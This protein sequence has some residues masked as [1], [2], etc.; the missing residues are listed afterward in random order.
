MNWPVLHMEIAN[1]VKR[2]LMEHQA[3]EKWVETVTKF[4]YHQNRALLIFM[5]RHSKYGSKN[6]AAEGHAGTMVRLND[7]IQRIRHGTSNFS[8]ESIEDAH[9][10]AS[11]YPLI[12]LMVLKG[13]WPD[14]DADKE[15]RRTA[16]R[17]EIDRLQKELD[18]LDGRAEEITHRSTGKTL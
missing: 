3:E 2:R 14:A 7:K 12:G 13:H 11:N 5:D 17:L 10:D 4:M 6:I 16:L 9:Y 18:G 15:S 1:E 8:D